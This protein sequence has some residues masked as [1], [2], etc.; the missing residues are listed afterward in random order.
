MVAPDPKLGMQSSSGKLHVNNCGDVS[1]IL[2]RPSI[3]V[4]AINMPT[5]IAALLTDARAQ[6]GVNVMVPKGSMPDVVMQLQQH[7][8]FM[9]R[10][11]VAIVSV[12]RMKFKNYHN[13][14]TVDVA[15]VAF[16]SMIS[17]DSVLETVLQALKAARVVFWMCDSPPHEPLSHEI[18]HTMTVDGTVV[19]PTWHTHVPE[20]AFR[21][22]DKW[23]DNMIHCT[24]VDDKHEWDVALSGILSRVSTYRR[25][26]TRTIT[27][28]RGNKYVVG[29]GTR[30][31]LLSVQDTADNGCDMMPAVVI[32]TSVDTV[33]VL[34]IVGSV[35][36]LRP[37]TKTR[38]FAL[39]ATGNVPRSSVPMFL[40]VHV[41]GFI[42]I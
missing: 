30:C 21:V 32:S 5:E 11:R 2:Q 37:H 13:I 7:I 28:A 31:I 6:A 41:P 3:G 4:L 38:R 12:S 1:T 36:S 10:C 14:G 33:T 8:M 15:I 20:S 9:H 39:V 17:H 22:V 16:A 34:T 26:A 19:Q 25:V 23:D 35:L 27:D 40:H 42:L 24:G 29:T 18:T